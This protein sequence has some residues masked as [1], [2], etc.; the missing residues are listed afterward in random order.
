M[1]IRLARFVAL[2]C[3][4][5][6][7]VMAP[8]AAQ[9]PPDKEDGEGPELILNRI[10]YFDYQRA[11]PLK[12]IPAGARLHAL[13]QLR[14]MQAAEKSRKDQPLA[15]WTQIGSP[16]LIPS[17][18]TQFGGF[19]TASGRVTSIVASP[20]AVNRVYLGGAEGGIWLSTNSGANW[21]PLTDNQPSLAIGGLAI[22]PLNP[23]IIYAG[24]GEE[25]FN[26][27]AYYG[28]GI[29]KSTDG[30][31]TWTRLA[32]GKFG[33]C[34]AGQGFLS[35]LF[36]GSYIGAIAVN[37]VNDQVLLATV[38]N[39]CPQPGRGPGVYIS[40]DGGNT[41]TAI[42]ALSGNAP[43]TSVF[44][45]NGNTAYAALGY[46]FGNAANG[47]Y[48]TTNGGTSWNPANG[49]GSN[50]LPSGTSVGRI[51][52]VPAP[53]STNILYAAVSMPVTNLGAYFYGLYKTIDGGMN[54]TLTNAPDFCSAQCFYDMAVAV[55][56]VD[57][58]LV[59]AAGKYNYD[60]KTQT[61]VIAS[62]NGGDTWTLVGASTGGGNVL[63][64]TDGHTLAFTAD[65]SLL[66]VG[67]DG[68][69]VRTDTPA[70]P[71]NLNWV[72]LNPTLGVIQFYPGFAYSFLGVLGGTQDNGSLVLGSGS[73]W[74]NETC[75]DGGF[76]AIDVLTTPPTFYTA[77]NYE[78]KNQH[79][80]NGAG[81]YKSTTP[82]VSNSWM[83]F[84]TGI[85]LIDPALF[86]PPMVLDA[87]R[88]GTLYYGTNRVYQT[89]NGGAPGL[90]SLRSHC[91]GAWVTFRR[92]RPS[93]RQFMRGRRTARWR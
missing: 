35:S 23:Q 36:S 90:R 59:Y 41:W 87:S 61:T 29:L 24:T 77:C 31:N 34:A 80:L 86:I 69:A 66:Y 14:A 39:L 51:T 76:S 38:F 84:D 44:W 32:G 92:L 57:P 47:V 53:S 2:P 89:T 55:S 65:G 6:L 12:H 21:T 15:S 25:N 45:T 16:N 64:H 3:L 82:L 11:Y 7:F 4:L 1:W 10:N 40:S 18:G 75:G 70:T 54:W 60:Q 56:P 72:D 93:E 46:V 17:Q 81:V 91:R 27:D 74:Y 26:I 33:A 13:D 79:V 50:V 30:G 52:L 43:G 67:G 88:L 62:T 58:N 28:A 78:Q 8:A 63:V 22:D 85:D 37:P 20:D 19:P 68:G 83:A 9:N 48:V 42:P 73:Q 5:S 71:A 49:S